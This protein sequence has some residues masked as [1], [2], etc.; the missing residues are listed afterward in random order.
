MPTDRELCRDPLEEHAVMAVGYD[1]KNRQVTVLNSWGE[2]WG[3][4]GYFYMPYDFIT[5]SDVCFDFWK[6]SF[7]NEA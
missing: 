2:D 1:D 4:E 5:D 3:D 6:I 7:A